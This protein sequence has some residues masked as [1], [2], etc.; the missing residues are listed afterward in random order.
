MPI[1]AIGFVLVFIVGVLITF[2]KPL[3]GIW[4]YFFCF[5]MHPPGKYWGSYLPEIRWTLIV[6]LV[7]LISVLVHEKNKSEWLKY[8]ESKLL[9]TFVIFLGLQFPFVLSIDWHLIYFTLMAKLLILFFLMVTVVNSKQKLISVILANLI[10][11]AYIGFTALQ[12]HHGG[13]FER[14]GLPSINDSNLL[15]IHV[16]PILIIGAFLFLSDSVRKKYWLLVPLA[17][18]ANLIIMTGSRGAIV[19]LVITAVLL[20]L[21]SPS[22][23]RKPLIK[24]GLLAIFLLSFASIKLITDRIK[25]VTQANNSEQMDT[26]AESRMVIINAQL[27][28]IKENPLMGAGHRTTLILSPLYIGKKYLTDTA[29]GALRGSHNITM[30]ILVDHGIIGLILFLLL[31]YFAIKNSF[32]LS[33]NKKFDRDI[34]LIS[35]GLG[36]ALIGVV[37]A[38]QFSNSKVLEITIWMIAFIVIVQNIAFE[39]TEQTRK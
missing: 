22:E 10:G 32:S 27:E 13:R 36:G 5:Y 23:F 26:S 7:T 35:M 17:Y 3:V 31:I 30:A 25:L 1:T 16:I 2:K 18:T 12:L 24:W 19:A 9:I 15:G 29:V 20:I 37:V 33:R 38:S 21:F 39:K 11:C 6:A 8:K 34:R 28:M 4:L 14:A